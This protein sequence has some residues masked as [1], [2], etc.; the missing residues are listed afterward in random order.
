MET[1]Y[2]ENPCGGVGRMKLEMLLSEKEMKDKCGLFARVT[3]HK[4]EILGEHRHTGNN[5][6]YFVLSGEAEY[7]DNGARRTIKA[8]DVTWTPDGSSHGI[9]NSKGAEDF[10]FMALIIN[11]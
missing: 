4:G 1:V 10:V 8:G 11:S 9:D 5:E 3:L 6:C 7:I 2:E